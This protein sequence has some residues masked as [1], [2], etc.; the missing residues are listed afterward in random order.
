MY[1]HY[2]VC[3]ITSMRTYVCSVVLKVM[4]PCVP[5]PF[6]IR[7]C[8]CCVVVSHNFWCAVICVCD[9]VVIHICVGRDSFMCVP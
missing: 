8:V 4:L 9:G 5:L 6:G 1:V 2:S 3:A 7:V